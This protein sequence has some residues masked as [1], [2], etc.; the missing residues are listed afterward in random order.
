M[1]LKKEAAYH[2]S[3][4]AI[5]A[6]LISDHARA[7]KGE[8]TIRPMIV[9]TPDPGKVTDAQIGASQSHPHYWRMR[10]SMLYQQL[11]DAIR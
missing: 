4:S 1:Y 3:L 8:F 7:H 11:Q 5:D 6:D 9:N 2:G 10:R